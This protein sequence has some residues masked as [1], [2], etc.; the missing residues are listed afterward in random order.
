MSFDYTHYF[1]DYTHY[2]CEFLLFQSDDSK[3]IEEIKGV[4]RCE[5]QSNWPLF[6]GNPSLDS[7]VKCGEGQTEFCHLSRTP[8]TDPGVNNRE[9]FKAK[10]WKGTNS[11][12][13][14]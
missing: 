11:H 6:T 10:P 5:N 9:G 12:F 13:N 2:F 7:C 3:A 1:F 14:N 8:F 4:Q